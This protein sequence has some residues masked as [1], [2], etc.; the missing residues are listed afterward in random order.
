MNLMKLLGNL[1]NLS[2]LQ[3]EIQGISEELANLS[4]DGSAG[5]D[6]VRATVNGASQVTGL[7][8]DPKLIED[9]DRELI[10]EL[11]IAAVNNAAAK[12][13]R[14]S[15]EYFQKRLAEKLDLGDMSGML[16]SLLPK[17]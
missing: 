16:S 14:E 3:G 2:K 8:I 4:F 9:Q 12:A 1:G 13:K 17:P 7:V 5:G 6:M 10:E 15:A 11:V